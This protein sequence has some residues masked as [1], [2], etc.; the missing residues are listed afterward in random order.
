MDDTVDPVDAAAD[1]TLTDQETGWVLGGSGRVMVVS[2]EAA[3][4]EG[5]FIR[6]ATVRLRAEPSADRAL[7]EILTWESVARE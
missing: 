3:A 5:T 7:F 4:A 6:R 1:D 2:I